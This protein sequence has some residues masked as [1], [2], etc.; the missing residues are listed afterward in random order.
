MSDRFTLYKM[1]YD[2]VEK[3]S[4]YRDIYL[5]KYTEENKE[6]QKVFI[7]D[8]TDY[9]EGFKLLNYHTGKQLLAFLLEDEETNE[10]MFIVHNKRTFEPIIELHSENINLYESSKMVIGELLTHFTVRYIDKV[11]KGHK[12]IVMVFNNNTGHLKHIIPAVESI[13]V[14]PNRNRSDILVEYSTVNKDRLY[15]TYKGI[16]TYEGVI[17]SN[18]YNPITIADKNRLGVNIKL[19][20]G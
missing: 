14:N 17:I 2:N 16:T 18:R 20:E 4:K 11:T 6:I 1:I 12:S 7:D 8:G 10:K 15:L 5:C 19:C 3:L 13:S 9:Y